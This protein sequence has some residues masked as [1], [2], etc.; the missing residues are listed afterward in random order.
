[1]KTIKDVKLRDITPDS[2]K[3][4]IAVKA[5]SE[6][7]DPEMYFISEN[8]DIPSIYANID[9]LSSL[10]LDH[11]AEQ[12]DVSTWH[13]KWN[14]TLK[15]SVLKNEISAKRKKG[16][17]YAVKEALKSIGSASSVT[18]WW[19]TEPKGIPHTFKINVTVSK[20]DGILDAEMQENII[21]LIDDAKPKRSHYE[22]LLSENMGTTFGFYGC[23]R[24]ITYKIIRASVSANIIY[25]VGGL[26]ML[27][28]CRPIKKRHL[29]ANT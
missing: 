18:E 6:A 7:V 15:R 27:S 2:I 14:V 28:A 11:L 17:L 1:M 21:S 8:V 4:D 26:N 9:K 25:S 3:D 10:A 22:F 5:I 19:Q 29:I 12:Y 20:I 13:E 24:P 16:T 23:I